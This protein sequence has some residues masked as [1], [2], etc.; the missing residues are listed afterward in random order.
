MNNKLN[1]FILVILTLS[2]I[3]NVGCFNSNSSADT[4]NE[5]TSQFDESIKQLIFSSLTLYLLSIFISF[6]DP[7]CQVS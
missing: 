2:L 4:T 3:F 5:I 6:F 1:F 7:K